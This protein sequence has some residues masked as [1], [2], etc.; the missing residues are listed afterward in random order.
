M[1]NGSTGRMLPLLAQ[2]LQGID[3]GVQ[4]GLKELICHAAGSYTLGAG[5]CTY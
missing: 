5:Y 4:D 2:E 3:I 1:V